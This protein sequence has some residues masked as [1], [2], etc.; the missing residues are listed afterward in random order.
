MF[1]PDPM[2]AAVKVADS[3]ADAIA[4]A[5]ARA[6]EVY[7]NGRKTLIDSLSVEQFAAWDGAGEMALVGA[8]SIEEAEDDEFYEDGVVSHAA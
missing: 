1:K 3:L 2:E 5:D 6:A 4:A 7:K 8:A